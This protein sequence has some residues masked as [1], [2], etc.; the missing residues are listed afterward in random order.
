[1]RLRRSGESCCGVCPCFAM[2]G[3]VDSTVS[4]AVGNCLSRKGKNV[5]GCRQPNPI[6]RLISECQRMKVAKTTG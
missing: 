4:E 5:G 1:M 6:S 2:Q 3:Y